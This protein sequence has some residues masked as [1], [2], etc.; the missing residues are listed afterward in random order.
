MHVATESVQ[1][2]HEYWAR[3]LLG[4]MKS[5]T[6]LRP[7]LEGVCRPLSALNL[8]EPPAYADA[9]S[10]CKGPNGLLLGFKAQAGAPL[11]GR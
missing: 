6:Q 11:S 5:L 10:F 1:L 3:I 7:A 2:S 8:T 4:S 9:L